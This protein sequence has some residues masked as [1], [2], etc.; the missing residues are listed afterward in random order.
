[1]KSTPHFG[2]IDVYLDITHIPPEIAGKMILLL[3]RLTVSPNGKTHAR[4]VS[5][6]ARKHLPLVGVERESSSTA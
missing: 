1:V 4:L 6:A 5:L 2:R 3:Q